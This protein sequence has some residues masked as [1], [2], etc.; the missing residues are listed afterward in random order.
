[1]TVL[2]CDKQTIFVDLLKPNILILILRTLARDGDRLSPILLYTTT[3]ALT[4]IT[5]FNNETR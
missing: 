5:R 2:S 4:K 3:V 1:M